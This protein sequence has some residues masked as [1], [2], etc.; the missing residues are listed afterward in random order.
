MKV[1]SEVA[2]SCSTLNDPMDYSLPGSSA[3]GVF[4]AKVLEWVAIAKIT[5]KDLKKRSCG[6]AGE[7]ERGPA[8]GNADSE[9]AE[10]EEEGEEQAEGSLDLS[11]VVLT[12]DPRFFCM[13][14]LSCGSSRYPL[15]PPF[16]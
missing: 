5:S 12:P 11:P 4:Q 3:H 1:K 16:F 6:A 8:N 15:P 2:Q 14:L 13:R 10:E 9:V 7:W